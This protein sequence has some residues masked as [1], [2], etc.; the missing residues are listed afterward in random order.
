MLQLTETDKNGRV[1]RSRVIDLPDRPITIGR[2]KDCDYQL[3]NVH[4]LSRVQCTIEP[5]GDQ[6]VLR[7]GNGKRSEYGL[8]SKHGRVKELILSPGVE[9]ELFKSPEYV[10][11]LA[12]NDEVYIDRDTAEYPVQDLHEQVRGLREGLI[13]LKNEVAA[14][15]NRQAAHE[16][17]FDGQVLG[18]I[19][20]LKHQVE[21]LRAENQSQDCAIGETDKRVKRVLAGM[22]A[23]M[24]A[25]GGYTIGLKEDV[26]LKTVG[27]FEVAV[28]L[29]GGAWATA[30][31]QKQPTGT[32]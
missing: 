29:G 28:G 6:W 27:I 7:D 25:T 20:D 31:R 10:V 24:L 22:A 19:S 18:A 17:T 23:A 26:I 15:V 14:L 5:D 30:Q 4:H 9:V 11:K 12:M 8:W 32:P 1:I 16:S 2:S 21:A 13:D 3:R